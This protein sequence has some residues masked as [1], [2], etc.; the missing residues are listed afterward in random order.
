MM[1][2]SSREKWSTT[3]DKNIKN[4]VECPEHTD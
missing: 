2:I 1:Y 4:N 3:I